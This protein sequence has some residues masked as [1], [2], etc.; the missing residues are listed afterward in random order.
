M[1]TTTE[2]TE[3]E[4]QAQHGQ[5]MIE[6]TLRFWTDD[7]AQPGHILP[8]HCHGYG[9]AKLS[10]NPS[11]GIVHARPTPFNSLS[12]IPRVIE[13]LFID[14]GINVHP[15]SRMRK[16]LLPDGIG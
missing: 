13:E 5:K 2:T 15:D 4:A 1:P 12:E 9:V 6:I 7:I 8:K 11:H 14:H 3:R 10:P 16:Y